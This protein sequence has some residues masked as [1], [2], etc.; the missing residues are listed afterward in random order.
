M[1]EVNFKWLADRAED[2]NETFPGKGK[3]IG[4]NP[5]KDFVT[6]LDAVPFV[7]G[8]AKLNKARKLLFSSKAGKW[9]VSGA[10]QTAADVAV[11]GGL[12]YALIK[13]QG[14]SGA[15]SLASPTS[16]NKASRPRRGRSSQCPP[17]HKWDHRKRRCVRI[18]RR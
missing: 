4:L 18:R 6:P 7:G 14:G 10:W 3:W 2:L 5:K 16:T 13:S 8:A 1:S 12:L 17:G 15:P 11:Y 9:V